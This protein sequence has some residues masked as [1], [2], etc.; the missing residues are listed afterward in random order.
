MDKGP[1][2]RTDRLKDMLGWCEWTMPPSLQD[3]ITVGSNPTPSTKYMANEMRVCVCGGRNFSDREYIFDSLDWAREDVLYPFTLLN[4]GAPG[5]DQLST[6]WAIS[7]GVPYEVFEADWKKHG[8]AAG[9]IRNKL[10][11]ASG[12]DV[13]LAFP[14]GKGTQNM[15]DICKKSKDRIVVVIKFNGR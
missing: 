10:M 4:G 12:I 11:L 1:R 7:R 3:G 13:L 8:K 15:V 6:E 9:P 5:A 14:G 2:R